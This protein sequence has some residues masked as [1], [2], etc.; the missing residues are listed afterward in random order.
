MMPSILWAKYFLKAQGYKVNDNVVFQDNKSTMLLEKKRKASSSRQTK[1][2]YVRYSFIR[3]RI[4]KGKVRVE[5]CLTVEMVTDYMTKLLQGSTFTRFSNLI[6]G[7]LPKKEEFKILI[8]DE[9]L[10]AHHGKMA[11]K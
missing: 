8:R 6:M 9:I 4:S 10:E 11:H 1:H 3:D 7:A 5:W 2:I